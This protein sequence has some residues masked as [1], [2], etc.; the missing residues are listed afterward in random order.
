LILK[1]NEINLLQFKN[2]MMQIASVAFK[3]LPSIH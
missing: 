1:M 2:T 3:Y